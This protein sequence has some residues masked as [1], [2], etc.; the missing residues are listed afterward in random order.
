M[1]QRARMRALVHPYRLHL[2]VISVASFL[3]GLVEG[4]FLVLVTRLALA[5]TDGSDSIGEVFG[6][7]LTTRAGVVGVALGLVLL[8]LGLGILAT[9]RSTGLTA[10]VRLDLRHRLAAAYLDAS[11]GVQQ[12]EPAGHLTQLVTAFANEA[13]R[14]VASLANSLAA[15]LSLLALIG[16]ALWI[17]PIATLAILLALVVL[18]SVLAPVRRRI[19]VRSRTAAAAQLDF[20]ASVSELGALGLEM[21]SFGVKDRFGERI[22]ALMAVE[23]RERR[24]ADTIGASLPLIYTSLAYVAVLGS[25]AVVGLAGE[26]EVSSLGAVMLVLLRSLSYG[27]ALQVASAN[28]MQSL[29]FLDRMDAAIERYESARASGG[30]EVPDAVV[31]IELRDVSFSYGSSDEGQRP[32]SL[33]GV[34]VTIDAGQTVGVI[35]P[36]GAGKS[37]LVQLLLGLRDPTSGTVVVGGAD[38]AQVDRAWWTDRV[39]FVAQDA[40]LFTGTVAENIRF[41][42]DGI[43]DDDL[44]RAAEQAHVLAEVEALPDGFATHLGERA[45]QLSGGQRQR[46][47]IA[48][49]LVGRPELLVL[50]EP[51]SALDVRSESLIRQTIADLHGDTTVVIIAHRM[52]TLEMCDRLLVVE[53]GRLLASGSPEEL[54]AGNEFY[55]Q[56]LELSGIE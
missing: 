23:V 32:L 43:D 47:S 49:A 9:V 39:A 41:F 27:Q 48:R 5:V 25:L 3:G 17:D 22:D 30:S 53:G 21:Q 6:F 2:V 52:S 29:P 11:W 8:R 12:S 36:S 38:L 4:A 50:D 7:E 51:T 56:A 13:V 16:G 33:D 40:L 1:S 10:Q 34:S 15:A 14:T 20:S 18:G 42:R 37:T 44:R 31:P 55:R 28:M 54:R 24:A 19:R 26:G 46:L 45:S 35:G